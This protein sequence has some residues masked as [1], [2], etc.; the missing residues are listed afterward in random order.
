MSLRRPRSFSIDIDIAAAILLQLGVAA[1]VAFVP[2]G[3]DHPSSWGLDFDDFLRTIAV[4]ALS[5]AFG[6]TVACWRRRWAY[7]ALQVA[8]LGFLLCYFFWPPSSQFDRLDR[9][10][11]SPRSCFP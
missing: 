7:V 4:C 2:L 9:T 5:F 10:S 6:V 3:F 8:L 1:T 11:R